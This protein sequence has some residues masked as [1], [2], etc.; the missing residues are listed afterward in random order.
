MDFFLLHLIY[1]HNLQ[2][3][4]RHGLGITNSSYTAIR[5]ISM[6]SRIHPTHYKFRTLAN[7]K[8]KKKLIQIN[9]QRGFRHGECV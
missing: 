4:T 7:N 9:E 6:A 8:F 3:C 2:Q 1:Y 5:A